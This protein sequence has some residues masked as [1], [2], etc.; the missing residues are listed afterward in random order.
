MALARSD[1]SIFSEW[2]WTVDRWL[3]AS[4]VLLL[5]CGAVLTMAATPVVATRLGFPRFY[6]VHRHLFSLIPSGLLMMG[7][8]FLSLRNLRRLALALF[9]LFIGVMILVPFTGVEVK[10]ARRWISVGS[11]SLQPSEFVKPAL[12]ILTAWALSEKH[13]NLAF[14]GNRI[15][16]GL[17]LLFVGL[18]AIQPD[19]GMAY[20]V[21]GVW[22]AQLFTNGLPF[23]VVGV[24]LLL[25]IG[26]LIGAYFLFP[27]V[28]H[29]IDRFL[30]PEIGD[31][32]QIGKSLEAFSN[33]GI[34]GV[35]PGEGTVKRYLP[36]AHAD[37]VFSVIGEEFGL[38][39]CLLLVFLYA[40]I[41]LR[42]F[43]AALREKDTFLSLALVGLLTEFGLQAFINMASTLHLVPTKGMTLPFISYGG[44]SMVAVG[45]GMGMV[46]A[47]TRRR[48]LGEREE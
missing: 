6:F 38:I 36:D 8:S 22:F 18:L 45:I 16:M 25:A 47:L 4:L 11:F 17:C 7:I 2:W 26:G 13:V 9:V 39:F 5:S 43:A 3:L 34:L 32:Y 28:A 33:G 27:H 1:K 41:V 46:L 14:P 12:A 48:A 40:F 15:A 31:H 35:G 19:L 23:F 42:G 29:R 10:G 44:S 30:N 21:F 37:F 24:V 20:V